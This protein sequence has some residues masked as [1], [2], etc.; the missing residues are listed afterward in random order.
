MSRLG[1]RIFAMN[2]QNPYRTLKYRTRFEICLSLFSK[3]I[4]FTVVTKGNQT[5]IRS[6]KH[7]VFYISMSLSHVA[8]RVVYSLRLKNFL[9][10]SLARTLPRPSWFSSWPWVPQHRCRRRRRRCWASLAPRPLG[11][12]ESHPGQSFPQ[13]RL[14]KMNVPH[15]GRRARLLVFQDLLLAGYLVPQ[16]PLRRARKRRSGHL[17]AVPAGTVGTHCF[18]YHLFDL[19]QATL[20]VVLEEEE[21]SIGLI[22]GFLDTALIFQSGEIL[23]NVAGRPGYPEN[24]D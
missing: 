22:I 17:M 12:A 24:R 11:S 4:L 5:T 9:A 23:R 1:L 21:T 10:R 3:T 20:Q 19:L 14:S 16:R 15:I 6:S 7:N 2:L 13:R 8:L 18:R